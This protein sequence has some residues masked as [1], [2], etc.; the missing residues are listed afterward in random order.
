[1]RDIICLNRMYSGKYLDSNLGHECINV[2][3]TDNGEH[4][5]YLNEDGAFDLKYSGRIKTIL[6]T[7]TLDNNREEVFAK[8]DVV[9]DVYPSHQTTKEQVQYIV[10]NG[11]TYGKTYAHVLFIGNKFQ[12]LFLTFKVENYSEVKGTRLILDFS[13]SNTKSSKTGEIVVNMSI[14][15]AKRSLKRYIMPS[16]ANSD[17]SKLVEII[18]NEAL[19]ESNVKKRVKKT[20]SPDERRVVM[21]DQMRARIKDNAQYN[22]MF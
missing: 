7:K 6:L 22:E 17:Y 14:N 1:M 8:A 4:Y 11:V 21:D 19:W 5:I 10:A 20:S 9:F 2:Y 15:K 13:R 12:S 16:T 18:S 3:E